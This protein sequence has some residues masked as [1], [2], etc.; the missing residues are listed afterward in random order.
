[1]ER[2]G[3]ADEKESVA[4]DTEKLQ[5]LFAQWRAENRGYFLK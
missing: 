4:E 2:R 1:M 5:A 3:R